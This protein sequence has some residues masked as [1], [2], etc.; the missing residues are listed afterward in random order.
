MGARE[1]GFTLV[2]IVVAVGISVILLVA[3]GAWMLG[4]RPGA[5]R[6][7]ADD[8]DAD[9]A[10]A[11]AI[12]GGSGNG[13]TIAFLPRIGT[14]GF[15]MRVYSGRP[16]A[17][18]AVTTTNVMDVTSGATVSEATF[19][20]PPFAIFLNSAGYPTGTGQY[21]NVSGTSVSFPVIA[22]QPPCPSN[23]IVLT[24]AN[25]QGATATRSLQ[26]NAD[27]AGAATADPSPT[28][29]VPK[30]APSFMLAHWTSDTGPLHFIAAEFGY[31]HWYASAIGNTCATQSS[32][33]GAPPATFANG[34]PYSLTTAGEMS[35]SPAPP[36]APYSWPTGDPNDPPATFRLSPVLH[37]GGLCTVRIVDDYNQEADANV[38]VMGDLQSSLS[39]LTFLSP[40]APA[41]TLTFGKTF[42]SE[43]LNLQA[44]RSACAGVVAV[45]IPPPP[46]AQSAP[47]T[48]PT[49]ATMTVTPVSAGSC[50][51]VVGD[52]YGEPTIAIPI[53][54]KA[55]ATLSVW[56]PAVEYP[57]AGT[58]LGPCAA[59]QARA[60]DGTGWSSTDVL[61]DQS[62]YGITT[63]A[64]GCITGPSGATEG[65]NEVGYS[66]AFAPLSLGCLQSSI[67]SNVGWVPA[68]ALG[69]TA[70]NIESGASPSAGCTLTYADDRGMLPSAPAGSTANALAQV[71]GCSEVSGGYVPVGSTCSLDTPDSDGVCDG[72]DV[73]PNEAYSYD[74]ASW[75]ST[76]T[77]APGTPYTETGPLGS[78]TSQEN[79]YNKD[80]NPSYSWATIAFTRTAS[81]PATFYIYTEETVETGHGIIAGEPICYMKETLIGPS[82]VTVE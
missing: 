68:S 19:G 80:G 64:N 26:C 79:Y 23:G 76:L 70:Q 20:S 49:L 57:L 31:F 41:Q 47:S 7:A 9:F 1:R 54:V 11:R 59:N 30:L 75:S 15:I 8:F 60:F 33:T 35:A 28:P 24:F 63:D 38:Q 34:W 18:G 21:P 65:V 10:A 16:T 36:A 37:D 53:N 43:T 40:T 3:G 50:T 71:V 25:A 45:T 44:A 56:P 39:S 69:P 55:A 12:A 77:S 2:E 66:G 17:S 73:P 42:D 29:N 81:G 58:S 61:A 48:T 5:L 78:L 13:A 62:Q 27:V 22:Q 74:F 67:L 82:Q 6:N 46:A 52:Q 14:P 51:L 72:F 32:D 4:M